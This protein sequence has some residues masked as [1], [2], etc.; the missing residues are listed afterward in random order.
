MAQ[1]STTPPYAKI[2]STTSRL[3]RPKS[4][5]HR[6]R[7]G[8]PDWGSGMPV[9]IQPTLSEFERVVVRL[10]LEPH[11][12]VA[13]QELR[14]WAEINKDARYVPE[15]LLKAWGVSLRGSIDDIS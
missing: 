13:S 2:S 1:Q 8:N 12:Y 11:E 15:R 9:P 5:L 14:E 10:G 7:R 3:K 4:Q 6:R